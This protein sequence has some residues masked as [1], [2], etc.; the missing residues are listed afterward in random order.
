MQLHPKPYQLRGPRNSRLERLHRLDFDDLMRVPFTGDAEED[1][2]L[3][4]L[5]ERRAQSAE[6]VWQR[7]LAEA[8]RR[9]WEPVR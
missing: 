1:G 5:L 9:A 7:G 6:K 4:H 2:P 3:L 8:K